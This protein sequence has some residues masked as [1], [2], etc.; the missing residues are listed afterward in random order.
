[1][2]SFREGFNTTMNK[3]AAGV[4]DYFKLFKDKVIS[5][6]SAN[7]LL[8]ATPGRMQ[9]AYTAGMGLGGAG[10]GAL[11]GAA[12]GGIGSILNPNQ[13]F[14]ESIIQGAKKGAF[15]GGVGGAGLGAWG[16]YG[17]QGPAIWYRL[18]WNK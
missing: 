4:G 3:E 11:G 13:D 5:G 7:K 10:A 17:R 9:A 8:N 1:M 15:L 14:G 2:T 6:I 18:G 16:T 12:L